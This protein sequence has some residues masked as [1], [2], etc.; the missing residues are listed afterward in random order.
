[1]LS[2]ILETMKLIILFFSI[3]YTIK[4]QKNESYVFI[5][6]SACFFVFVCLF[7]PNDEYNHRNVQKLFLLCLINKSTTN[8]ATCATIV[9]SADAHS[10][11]NS[12]A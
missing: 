9:V 10:S 6:L 11:V 2:K 5:Q 8:A 12:Y 4:N 1:M 3:Y 7:D